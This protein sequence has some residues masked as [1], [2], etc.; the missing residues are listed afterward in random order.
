LGWFIWWAH[1]SQTQDERTAT[2]DHYVD[3]SP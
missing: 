1:E 3:S 2:Y